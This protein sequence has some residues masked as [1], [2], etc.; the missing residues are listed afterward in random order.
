MTIKEINAM[1]DK[2]RKVLEDKRHSYDEFNAMYERIMEDLDLQEKLAHD[3]LVKRI[4]KHFKGIMPSIDVTNWHVLIA[5]DS[6]KFL[7][8]QYGLTEF[9][10]ISKKLAYK[11]IAE[12]EEVYGEI[13][14]NTYVPYTTSNMVDGYIQLDGCLIKV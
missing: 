9:E 10:N 12:Y 14:E 13:V 11:I 4:R 3:D 8:Y 6:S 2:H 5:Y 7:D 1:R